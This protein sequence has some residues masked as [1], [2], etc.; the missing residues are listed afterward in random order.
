MNTSRRAALA[1]A[2]LV[3]ASAVARSLAASLHAGPA[4]FPD[5][6]LY[7]ELARS[8]AATGHADVRGA[9]AHFAPLLASIVTAPAWLFGNV[10]TGYRVAQ[11][12]NACCVSLAAVPVYALGRTLRL[13]RRWAFTAAALSLLLPGLLYTSFMLSEPIAYPLVL[14]AAAA[15]VRALV[16]PRLRTLALFVAF[17]VLASFARLQFA[18]LLPCFLVAFAGLLARERRILRH[19]RAAG[20]LVLATA[21]LAAIGPARSTGYYPS[22]LHVH[23]QPGNLVS[24]V[25][26]NMLILAIGTG[27]VLLPGS[28]LGVWEA[29]AR[30]RLRAERAFALLTLT[31]T[32]G[33]LLQASIYGDTH[34]AQT[35][36]TFY[37][38]P[39]WILSF[40]LYAQRGWERRRVLTLA[41][42][43]LVAAALTTPL[44][45]AAYGQGKIHAPELFAV[46]RI[47]QAF[48]GVAG[49]TSSAFLLVLAGGI[50]LVTACASVRP[51]L[52]TVVAAAF[53][54]SFMAVLS[55][56][57]YAFDA[58]NTREVR[59]AFAGPDPSW[60]DNLHLGMVSMVVTPNGLMTDPLEQMFW[61]RS[62]DRAVLL[63]DAK[64][65]DALPATKSI[66]EGNGA[67]FDNGRPLTGPALIDQYSSSVQVRDARRLGSDPTSV[68]YRPEGDLDLRLLAIGE[69]DRAWLGERG[70]LVVWPSKAG[71]KVAGDIILHLGLPPG[72]PK[73]GVDFRGRHVADDITVRGGTARTAEIPVCGTGPVDLLFA[74]RASG[75]LGDGRVVSVQSRPPVFEP[76]PRACSD[77][78]RG[79]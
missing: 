50:A 43:G 7:S 1:V 78:K 32:A 8:I 30:P 60:I 59:A 73:I 21:A 15:G 42:L 10:A 3:V 53:A 72:V 5:E 45:T 9:P 14:A 66:V 41:G 12:I 75:R 19:W 61:N 47:E 29:I 17:V 6:Y 76:A 36:Y 49:T 27:L 62:V 23:V 65:P 25:G 24:A 74:A 39:L 44:T 64:P 55:V 67:L 56:G 18:V 31:V 79:S 28:L 2:G 63:P 51:R 38:V 77:P 34:V 16:A 37:L 40:F 22:F 11:A 69:Y 57:A 71:G 20:A 33:I 35:R 13:E 68:L 70:A 26:L 46:A 54:A 4:Y 52:A 58:T 48:H